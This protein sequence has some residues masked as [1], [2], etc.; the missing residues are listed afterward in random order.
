MYGFAGFR[1]VSEGGLHGW[2]WDVYCVT[3][4]MHVCFLKSTRLCMSVLAV[5]IIC[6]ANLEQACADTTQGLDLL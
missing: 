5:N 3:Y 6:V 4:V 2:S 1:A